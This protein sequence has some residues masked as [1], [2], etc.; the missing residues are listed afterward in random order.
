M[1][2]EWSLLAVGAYAAFGPWINPSVAVES[3]LRID[4]FSLALFGLPVFVLG[5]GG[6]VGGER[7]EGGTSGLRSVVPSILVGGLLG[8]AFVAPWA[9]FPW[10][11]GPALVIAWAGR[12]DGGRGRCHRL[13]LTTVVLALVLNA[14]LLA[15]ISARGLRVSPELFQTRDFRVNHLLADVPLHDV[16]AV[17]LKGHP[18]PTLEDLANAF[19]RF[20]PFQASPIHMGLGV[21]R[22]LACQALGWEDPRWYDPEA[23]LLNR[24]T[25]E[26]RRRST[27]ESG[28]T[29]GIWKV[30]YAHPREGVVETM[31][32]TA[33][34]AVAATIGD[35]PGGPRLFLS[36]RVREVNWT[37]SWY[38]RLI[39]PSR[40][41]FVYPTLL[42]QFAHT[43]EQEGFE[44]SQDIRM[45][46]EQ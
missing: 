21:V 26:D 44:R 5:A 8:A 46:D 14:A 1:V 7:F 40:R 41:Y 18:S 36:F 29:R 37:T 27:T 15:A 43:W 25:E 22:E 2:C 23:S 38:M 45:G 6:V 19:Q 16:W 12:D 24:L 32:G 34:V 30:L 31:N 33:H 28:T 42:K 10:L 11:V 39:D 3:S 35:G 17:D 20:S 9:A 13:R 4:L